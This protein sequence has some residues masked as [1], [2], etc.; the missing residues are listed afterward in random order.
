MQKKNM[1]KTPLDYYQAQCQNGFITE[2]PAQLAALKHFERVFHQLVEENS[3]RDGLFAFFRKPHLVEGLYLWGGVGIGK[4]FLMDCFFQ[5]LPFS[6][7]MR[8]HFYQFMQ[9]VHNELTRY[10][11]EKDPL[12]L[13]ADDIAN[14]AIVL[15]FDELFVSDI[16]DAML[17]GR[18]FK[19]LFARGVSLVTT[20]NVA[21]D[22]LYK[23]GLQRLQFL[24]AIAALKAN[25]TVFHVPTKVDYRLR[26][27]QEAGVFYTPLDDKARQN[28]EKSFET[29]TQHTPVDSEP[30]EIFGRPIKV[31]KKSQRVIW[32]EFAEICK[33][34]RSQKDYL[35]SAE[36]YQTVFISDIPAIEAS[37]KDTIC[38]FISLVDVFY[39]ARIRLVISAAEPVPQIYS[40]GYMILEYTRTHSRLLEM[41]SVD[42]FTGEFDQER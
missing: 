36:Q 25:M 4:T 40:R 16:T 24:P 23:Y 31:K 30:I 13:V 17:L 3:K 2:D 6:N 14:Q 29:L 35:A 22:D 26:H 18:L 21:P 12:Q 38:L 19:A 10:Q 34:P 39:D 20:S 11:G 37:A 27:L 5:A 8:M 9:L 15:C 1:L 7:K 28:M 42:Y 32:F 41:Q 33:V